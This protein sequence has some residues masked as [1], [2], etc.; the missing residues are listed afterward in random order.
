M[1]IHNLRFLIRLMEGIRQAI[2]EDRFV[3]YKEYVLNKYG[4]DER[5]F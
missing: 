3:E 5:G 2:A 1:S 4:F